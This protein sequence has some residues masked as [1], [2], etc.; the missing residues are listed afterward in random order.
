MKQVRICY[1]AAIEFEV[2]ER[3]DGYGGTASDTIKIKEP[4][5]IDFEI[6]ND[7]KCN[8]KSIEFLLTEQI[9]RIGFLYRC[10]YEEKDKTQKALL[11]ESINKLPKIDSFID[12]LSWSIFEQ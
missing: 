2:N 9:E 3:P 1:S 4:R 5:Y 10:L 12:I 6:D 8:P 7:F 11:L